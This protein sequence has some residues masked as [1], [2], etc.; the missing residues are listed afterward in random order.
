M[1]WCVLLVLVLALTASAQDRFTVGSKSF[2]ESVLLGE[3]LAER[4]RREGLDVAH[5][6]SLRGTR[7]VFE[8]VK[9]GAIDA[10]PEYTGT[11][12]R[13]VFADQGLSSEVEL[14]VALAE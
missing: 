1:R 12:L 7:L 14:R 6:A 10:Y 5:T 9:S 4:A 11:L 8:A 2:T 3:I 13:E